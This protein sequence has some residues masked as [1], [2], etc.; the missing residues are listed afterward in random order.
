MSWIVEFSLRA[1]KFLDKNHIPD[2]EVF[3]LIKEALFK[4]RGENMNVSVKKLKGKWT[5]FHRI[6]KGNMRIIANFNFDSSSVFIDVI[7]WR[8]GAYK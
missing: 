1:E 7:D 3:A 5:G 6:R 2:E 4:F 8:G